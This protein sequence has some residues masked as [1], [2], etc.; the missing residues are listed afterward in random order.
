[1]QSDMIV[2]WDKHLK[3]G[4]VW[5]G[6]VELGMMDTPGDDPQLL[7]VSVYV[8]ATSQAL[9]QYIIA[10]MYPDYESISVDDEPTRIATITR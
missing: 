7:T 8:I 2:S 5:H 1:M 4:N 3:N 6:I 10:T 9:A